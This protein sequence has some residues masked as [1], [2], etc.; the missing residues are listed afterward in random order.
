MSKHNQQRPQAPRQ[1]EP[2]QAPRD[3]SP[4]TR[5]CAVCGRACSLTDATCPACGE[6][7]WSC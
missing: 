3:E 1:T 5:R 4:K 7:S 6:A 2:E